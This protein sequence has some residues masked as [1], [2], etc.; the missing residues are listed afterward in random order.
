MRYLILCC[1]ISCAGV[2]FLLGYFTRLNTMYFFYVLTGLTLLALYDATQTRHAILRNF[3]VVGHFRYLFEMIRPEIQQYFVENNSN[4]RPFNREERSLVYQRSKK[5]LDTLPFGTK[6]DHYANDHE[7]LNH[8]MAPVAPPKTFPRVKIGNDQC[9]RPYEA[10][11]LNISAMSFGALSANAISS[12][13]WGAKIGGFAHNTGE[14]AVSPYHL[15]KEGDLIW[16]LGT[17]YFGC[18]TEDGDFSPEMFQRRVSA[19]SI[20]MVEIKIS[21]GAKPG[22]GGILPGRKVSEEIA[23]I[24]DVEA[25]KTVHS[26]PYHRA[27]KTPVELLQFV[28]QLRQLSGGLPIGLKLCVGRKSE[29]L[30]LCKAMKKNEIY[31]DYIAIDGSEGGTGA[32]PLEF[33]NSIGTPLNDALAFVHSALLACRLR[34]HIKLIACGKIITGFDM[35]KKLALG[36]D[37]CYAARSMMFAIGCIQALRCNSNDC[38]TGVAT[39]RKDLVSGLVVKKKYMRVANYHHATIDSLFEMMSA[40]GLTHPLQ[41]RPHHIQKRINDRETKHYG[42]IYTFLEEGA[43]EARKAPASWLNSWDK[44]SAGHFGDPLTLPLT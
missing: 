29:F 23:R 40:A 35:L 3:P 17:G 30:G 11:L 10:S 8:T 42:E 31:P 32:A 9:K 2:A 41:I 38:P 44:A 20:K 14:G 19:S 36:A 39:Q 13:N 34:K 5:V 27:F 22:H 28:Q 1:L 6:S 16:Q 24:R 26:P 21:Q 43:F 12:L 18:R 15:E 37:L 7:W 4:G 33:S 25:G